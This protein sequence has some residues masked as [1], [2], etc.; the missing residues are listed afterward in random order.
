MAEPAADTSTMPTCTAV[1]TSSAASHS[2]PMVKSGI[3]ERDIS[4]NATCQIL[5]IHR[6]SGWMVQDVWSFAFRVVCSFA[7]QGVLVNL[8]QQDKPGLACC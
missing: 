7:F 8:E 1:G 6:L 2:E 5:P 4:M 3:S